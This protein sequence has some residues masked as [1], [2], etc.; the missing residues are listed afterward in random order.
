MGNDFC[1]STTEKSRAEKKQPS[2]L[3]NIVNSEKTHRFREFIFLIF[4]VCRSVVVAEIFE[5]SC[6]R[7]PLIPLLSEGLRRKKNFGNPYLCQHFY[8]GKNEFWAWGGYFY[9]YPD[10][11]LP[12]CS[13]SV[14]LIR[15]S[16]MTAV[17][18][19]SDR[20]VIPSDGFQMERVGVRVRPSGQSF[21]PL[22]LQP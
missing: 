8:G 11:A 18:G 5:E 17:P 2:N 10:G 4:R 19:A 7:K 16:L 12:Y 6:S 21:S 1:G 3:C 14:R 15:A 20:R 13:R 9:Q 22:L